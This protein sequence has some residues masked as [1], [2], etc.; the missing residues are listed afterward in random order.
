MKLF[1]VIGLCLLTFSHKATSSAS[2]QTAIKI[3]DP[4]EPNC[5]SQ[6]YQGTVI[7]HQSMTPSYIRQ[8]ATFIS[9]T[10]TSPNSAEEITFHTNSRSRDLLLKIPLFPEG[11]FGRSA[12]LTVQMTVANNVELSTGRDSDIKYGLSDGH[13]FVGF[14]LPDTTNYN[15]HAPC[16]GVEGKPGSN[17]NPQRTIQ[18]S[19][20][21]VPSSER[22][23]PGQFELTFKV[24]E[25]RA[26]CYTAHVGG[27]V[28]DTSYTRTLDISK[29]LA[30]EVYKDDDRGEKYGIRL[31]KLSIILEE[32]TFY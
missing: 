12:P 23:Y 8:H 16:Y 7:Y 14:M 9:S 32:E 24:N 4:H 2:L 31:I 6:S 5:D 29:G 13:N 22:F 28:K 1:V 21:T 20:P 25:G 26:Y 27:Y 3:C 11:Q 19:S 15:N 30:L 10:Q 18:K 17:L